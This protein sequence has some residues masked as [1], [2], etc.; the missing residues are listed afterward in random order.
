MD[1]ITPLTKQ[2]L[3]NR[4]WQMTTVENP[5]P[6]PGPTVVQQMRLEF[7]TTKAYKG[8][9]GRSRTLRFK[10]YG[11]SAEDLPNIRLEFGRFIK[12]RHTESSD[13]AAENVPSS[14][15]KTGGRYQCKGFIVPN[16]KRAVT[17]F[18]DNVHRMGEAEG[19]PFDVPRDDGFSLRLSESWRKPFQRLGAGVCLIG[20][21]KLQ[22]SNI[23]PNE[24]VAVDPNPDANIPYTDSNPQGT[25][26]TLTDFIVPFVAL[27][28]VLNGKR[29]FAASHHCGTVTTAKIQSGDP[30]TET[31]NVF[32]SLRFVK[33]GFRIVNVVTGET[34]PI[35]EFVP[36]VTLLKPGVSWGVVAHVSYGSYNPK[37]HLTASRVG[38]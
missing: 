20:R 34:S 33:C 24:Y 1:P 37:R 10:L 32:V 19:S 9:E 2:E 29:T 15:Y 4:G 23:N 22:A 8:S 13:L 11:V 30:G 5:T 27:Y 6:D 35:L 18:N 31:T 26:L 25:V 14:T 36:I 28:P 7:A 38:L 21:T 12:T 17:G 16:P 3:E